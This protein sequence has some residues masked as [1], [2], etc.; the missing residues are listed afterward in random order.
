MFNN[1]IYFIIVLLLFNISYV[2]DGQAE[3]F[4]YSLSM[5][6][7]LWMVLVLYCRIGFNRLVRMY[8]NDPGSIR[9]TAYNSL[10]M[11]LSIIAI[12][13]FSLDL[14]VLNLKYWIENIPVI[15]EIYVFQGLLGIILFLLYLSTI[16]YFACPFHRLV[17]NSDIQKQAF[18]TGNIKLNIPVIFPWLFLSLA[19]EIVALSP[20]PAFNLFIEKPA[21]QIL[22][23]TI[24]LAVIMIYLPVLIQYFWGCEPVEASYKADNIREFLRDVGL[25]YR[26]LLNWPVFEGKMM[27]AGIMGVVSK[28]RY[29]LI[30][31]SL[32]EILSI[33]ELKSVM[34]HEAGHAKYN[35]QL[36][37]ALLFLGYFTIAIGF[38]DPSFYFTLMGYIVH[39]LS[40]EKVSGNIYFIFVAVPM[41]LSLI[42]YFRF[43]MGFFMRH[44]ERQADTYSAIL[45]GDPSPIISS[46]EKIALLSGKIRDIPSWHHFS[47]RQRVEFL[48]KSRHDP[49]M[50][51]GHRR[52]LKTSFL[53][54]LGVTLLLI[55]LLYLTPVK[56]DISFSL[57]GSIISEQVEKNPQN[58]ELLEDLAMINYEMGKYEEA[59]VVYERIIILEK[60]R[61]AALNNFAWLII[62]TDVKKLRDPK[63]GLELAKSAVAIERSPIFLDTL[64][65]AYWVNGNTEK[66]I[67]IIK[68]AI[69]RDDTDSTHYR[70]QLEKFMK[71]E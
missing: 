19:F 41:L 7:I 3:S 39:K 32:M 14:F 62:T 15:G 60:N 5:F 51:S 37:Y 9:V 40:D 58:I 4:V 43:I 68:E 2:D 17:F 11:R 33:S 63:R 22:F 67:L 59:A 49:G 24:I 61:P 1:I 6:F 55:Y 18:I 44:F 47:I 25:K 12:L 36:L 52:M 26:K 54:Y 29:I 66:A 69:A 38:F 8:E 20:W 42:I 64:A 35:H 70:K 71:A 46:L 27:T 65:E 45:L 30:S 28:Y 13:I 31:D 50:I 56:R 16:W 34:A 48:N 21:G 10:V 53:I 23:F 57:I